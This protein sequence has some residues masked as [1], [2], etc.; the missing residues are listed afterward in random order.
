MTDTLAGYFITET[1]SILLFILIGVND[2]DRGL[3]SL[4]AD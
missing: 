4:D 1:V 2:N 3:L